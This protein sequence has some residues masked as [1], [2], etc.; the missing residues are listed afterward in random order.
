MREMASATRSS[1]STTGP[2]NGQLR[3]LAK[4]ALRMLPPDTDEIVRSFARM[5]NSLSLRN[6]PRWKSAVRHPPSESDNPTPTRCAAG[7]KS[8]TALAVAV[9]LRIVALTI[10]NCP[11]IGIGA[12]LLAPGAN[13]RPGTAFVKW[14]DIPRTRHYRLKCG[15][16]ASPNSL[17][18][19]VRS[20]PQISNMI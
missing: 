9:G 5:P 20:S 12:C 17:A 4:C 11:S 8:F 3:E 16:T 18:C 19:P 7:A 10:G 1:Q 2:C 15:N 13:R 14:I 6:A